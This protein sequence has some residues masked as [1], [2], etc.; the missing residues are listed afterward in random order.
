VKGVVT[1]FLNI[2]GI[3]NPYPARPTYQILLL[4]PHTLHYDNIDCDKIRFVN[5]FRATFLCPSYC[6][7]LWVPC[8]KGLRWTYYAYNVEDRMI[9]V[10]FP[11][12]AVNFSLRHRVKTGSGTHPASCPVC[13]PGALS[14]GVK[15]PGREAD[16]SPPSSA[17]VKEGVELYL[18]SPNT[19]SWSGV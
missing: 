13:V 5:L 11:A 17:E 10:Q 3:K 16:H 2:E 14:L 1:L 9:G 18:H 4:F 7:T 19:S 12:G 15:R 6:H 8:M